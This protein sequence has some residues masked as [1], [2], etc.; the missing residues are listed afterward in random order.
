LRD[1]TKGETS[2]TSTISLRINISPL[3]LTSMD[4]PRSDRRAVKKQVH[5]QMHK[6]SVSLLI[7]A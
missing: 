5:C 6:P 2:A 1:S 4:Q 3:S 7:T